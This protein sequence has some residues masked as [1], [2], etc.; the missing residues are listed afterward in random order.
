MKSSFLS[1]ICMALGA[2]FLLVSC[3]SVPKITIIKVDRELTFEERLRLANVYEGKGLHTKALDTYGIARDMRP[4]D[5]RVWFGMGNVNLNLH[6]LALAERNYLRAI[7]LAPEVGVYYNNL[8]WTYIEMGLLDK[9]QNNVTVG[10]GWDPEQRFIYLDTWGVLE[11]KKGNFTDAERLFKEAALI[12]PLE[13]VG[14]LI[15]VYVHLRDL[16]L[17]TG[18]NA[19]AGDVDERLMEL[20]GESKAGVN[21]S[22]SGES[23][24]SEKAS[25]PPKG[26]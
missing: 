7:K 13:E 6:K 5:S 21:T 24:E 2:I 3:G 11:E 17:M 19:E 18:R 9:A 14:G 16:Y 4:K 20:L 22:E 8:A 25:T 26:Y 15:E 12:I 23:G 1:G 10:L